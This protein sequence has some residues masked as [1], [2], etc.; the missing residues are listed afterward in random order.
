MSAVVSLFV[1][2]CSQAAPPS[3]AEYV[4]TADRVCESVGDRIED[5]EEEQEERIEERD[6]TGK[7]SAYADRPERWLRARIVPQ[8]ESMSNQLK[9]LAAPDG[10][11]IY[12]RDLYSDLDRRIEDLHTRPSKGRDLIRLDERLRDRFESY[13]MRVCGTV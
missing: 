9:G 11:H 12:L 1:A 7:P 3:Q 13:G 10:D 5:L 4:A 8:Y 2:S 6:R